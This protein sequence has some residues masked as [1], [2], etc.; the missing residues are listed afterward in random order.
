MLL[1]GII[2]RK[3]SKWEFTVIKNTSVTSGSSHLTALQ[4]ALPPV[5]EVNQKKLIKEMVY[6]LQNEPSG[7][8]KLIMGVF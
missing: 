3:L 5:H 1:E 6:F 8:L 4:G 2:K 7:A